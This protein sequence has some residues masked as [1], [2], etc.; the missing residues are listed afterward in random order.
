MSLERNDYNEDMKSLFD[1]CKKYQY[2]HCIITLKDG[3]ELD[4][5]IEDAD[6]DGVNVLIGEDVM[7]REFDEERQ[8]YGDTHP[9]RRRR[10]R[11]R[12]FRRRR[13]PFAALAALALLRYPPY[14]YPYY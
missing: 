2:Y 13:F 7:E 10:R 3:S 11:F 1:R 8:Y 5:I 9:R 4:G 6:M 14:Y 12:R